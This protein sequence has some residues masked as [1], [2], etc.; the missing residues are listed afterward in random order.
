MI[1]ALMALKETQF[2]VEL[3]PG[4]DE[5][6]QLA[7]TSSNQVILTHPEHPPRVLDE[8]TMRWVALTT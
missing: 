2:L 7:V 3:P 8:E 6:T 4:F 5:R 1:P